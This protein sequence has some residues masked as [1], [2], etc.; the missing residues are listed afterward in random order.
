MG[1][2]PPPDATNDL[3]DAE[4]EELLDA[5]ES[6]A[7]KAILDKLPSDPEELLRAARARAETKKSGSP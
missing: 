4:L 1:P 3:T 7:E 6:A 5:E 2:V